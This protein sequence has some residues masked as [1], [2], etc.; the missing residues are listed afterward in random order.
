MRSQVSTEQILILLEYLKE[1]SD[2]AKGIN[3]GVRRQ[4]D[5]WNECAN[6]LNSVKNGAVKD[7]KGWS[8]VLVTFI[9]GLRKPLFILIMVFYTHIT[10]S[11]YCCDFSFGV[12]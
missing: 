12:T 7:K 9:L 11:S 3:K 2:L 8:K 4:T 6:K 5:L 10:F 1:H